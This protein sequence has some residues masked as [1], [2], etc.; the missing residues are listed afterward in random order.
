M[1]LKNIVVILLI[2]FAFNSGFSQEKFTLSGTI[3]DKKNNET[4]IGVSI[5]IIGTKAFTTTNEYGFYSLT[6]PKGDYEINI[7]YVSYETITEKISL[8]QNLRKNYSLTE[9]GQVLNE[10][11][12]SEK[13]KTNTQK[14]EM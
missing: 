9:V 12:I 1:R 6:L 13:N 8:T 2:F 3:S 7:R 14:P 10:V 5:A 11:V 4:L